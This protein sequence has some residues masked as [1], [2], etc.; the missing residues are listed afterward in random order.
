MPFDGIQVLPPSRGEVIAE[1]ERL[2]QRRLDSHAADN[3]YGAFLARFVEVHGA[4]VAERLDANE[5]AIV[6]PRLQQIRA[7]IGQRKRPE[8]KGRRL[9]PVTHEMNPGAESFTY[10][11]WDA[12]GM[13]KMVANP[14]ADIEKVGTAGES[15]TFKAI[16]FALG[17]DV[18]VYDLDRS[19][20]AGVPLRAN[21]MQAVD[22][23]FENRVEY[24]SALGIPGTPITGLLNHA[25]V[26]VVNVPNAAG[27]GNSP[28]WGVD[29]TALEVLEDLQLAED[30][31]ASQSD[32]VEIADTLV[33]PRTKLRYAQKTP[34]Y[35]GAGSNPKETIL[36][37]FLDQSDGIKSVESWRYCNT[38]DAAGTGPRACF[39]KRAP[40]VVH[41]EIPRERR[42][43]PPQRKNLV[44]EVI[45]DMISAGVWFERP[46]AAVYVD[47]F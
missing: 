28:V 47:G 19:T 17:F 3:L 1:A 18:S 34:L 26:P 11:M 7:R 32:D 40:D 14:S 30:T 2:L 29:K 20:Y 9:V 13:A 41:H 12:R 42:E 21:K 33:L 8:R 15:F 44:M 22:E 10:E 36:S 25:N 4:S 31:V 6:A 35:T 27:G 5:S 45:S 24:I 39:Y 16:A 37:V 38:A 23:G 43:Y 46:L